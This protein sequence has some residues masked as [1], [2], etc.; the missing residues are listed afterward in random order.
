M[1]MGYWSRVQHEILLI[2]VK[3]VI[4][5]PEPTVRGRSIIHIR[6]EEEFIIQENHKN[7][8]I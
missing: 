3:G 5:S 2:G 7:F 1:G 6:N 8:V 4:E